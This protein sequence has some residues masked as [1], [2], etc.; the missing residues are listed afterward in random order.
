[1]TKETVVE[2]T[3]LFVDDDASIL[4]TMR[5]LFYRDG[6]TVL[7]ATCGQEALDLLD[8]NTVHVAIVDQRMTT[9][10]GIELLKRIKA[11]SP[12]TVSIVLSGYPD[13]ATIVEAINEGNVYRYIGKP[14]DDEHL[15]AMV[16]QS[17]EHQSQKTHHIE[18]AFKNIKTYIESTLIEEHL[19]ESQNQ[20]I[21]RLFY[22]NGH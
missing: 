17:F 5:R 13:V 19:S 8:Q 12:L 16:A 1:M 20:D 11:C 3:L 2:K 14:W 21:K 7:T 9:M 4:N 22:A 15:K 10:N 18:T 6:Y